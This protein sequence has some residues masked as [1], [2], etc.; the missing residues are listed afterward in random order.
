M[1][2]SSFFTESLPKRPKVTG[3]PSQAFTFAEDFWKS[4][5][6]AGLDINHHCSWHGYPR[7]HHL[8]VPFWS[9][10]SPQPFWST[11]NHHRQLFQQKG[12]IQLHQNWDSLLPT[13]SY[14]TPKKDFVPLLAHGQ[15]LM[16]EL[17][18]ETNN[19]KTFEGPVVATLLCS[20][21]VIYYE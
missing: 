1:N 12:R 7:L 20:F 14:I 15:D 8:A 21:F 10:D 2:T 9:N 6:K 17:L 16:E 3:A 19:L 18:G 13:F 5:P 11:D 4:S